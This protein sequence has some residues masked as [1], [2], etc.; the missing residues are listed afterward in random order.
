[1]TNHQIINGDCITE[2]RKLPDS[3]VELVVTD[4]PF[5]IGK[6]YKSYKDSLSMTEYLEW[7]KQWLTECIRIMKDGA[8]LYL[9]NYPRNNAYLVPWLD[10]RLTHNGWL[11][12][13]YPTNTGLSKTRYTRT[14]HSILFYVKGKPRKL[15]KNDIALPY[16]NPTDKRVRGMVAAGSKGIM[17]YDVFLFNI[18]KN[19]NKDKTPH[20]CQLPVEL[21]ETFV[22]G[23]SNIGETV[24][25]CFAGSFTTAKACQN[26]GRNSINIELDPTYCEIGRKRLELVNPV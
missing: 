15:N 20:P 11:T 22:K 10:E 16:R 5:N 4:P 3:L 18:V 14:Q 9:V 23:S 17:P 13:H 24:L 8:S 7:C 2:L 21:I 25:D 6:R 19:V 1:M 12:W 26:T